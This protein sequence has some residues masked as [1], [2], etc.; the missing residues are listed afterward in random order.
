[1]RDAL[2]EKPDEYPFELF[3]QYYSQNVSLNWTFDTLD[4]I[5]DAADEVILHSIFEKHICNLKNWT[6]TPEFQTRFP[7]MTPAIYSRD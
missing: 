6:V 4:A 5:A 7:A 3:S 2:I 1:M